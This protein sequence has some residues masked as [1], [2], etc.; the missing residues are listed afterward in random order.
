VLFRRKSR[1][2]SA[3]GLPRGRIPSRF[4]RL[5]S[6]M[7]PTPWSCMGGGGGEV[8]SCARAPHTASMVG[9]S[10]LFV[11]CL[12]EVWTQYVASGDCIICRDRDASS[13]S[14]EPL[15]LNCCC[16]CCPSCCPPTT[17]AKEKGG[18]GV[19]TVHT[20]CTTVT[21]MLPVGS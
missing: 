17:L 7:Q 13:Q 2:H 15:L 4:A 21:M 10:K 9:Y 18:I 1:R 20:V 8:A 3:E 19:V 16:C 6:L 12:A 11:D 5:P 14:S